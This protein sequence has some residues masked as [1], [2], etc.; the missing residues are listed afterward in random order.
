MTPSESP[1]PQSYLPQNS[2]Q[3]ASAQTQ[4]QYAN[5]AQGDASQRQAAVTRTRPTIPAQQ[6]LP[7]GATYPIQTNQSAQT[8]QGFSSSQRA[9]SSTRFIRTASDYTSSDSSNGA[10]PRRRTQQTRSEVW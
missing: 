3:R 10:A 7:T 1:R 4:L 5:T 6:N 2:G 8:G 9:Q